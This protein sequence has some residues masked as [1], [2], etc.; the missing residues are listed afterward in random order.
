MEGSLSSLMLLFSAQ[1]CVF[2]VRYLL[3]VSNQYSSPFRSKYSNAQQLRTKYNKQY[4][5]SSVVE[6]TAA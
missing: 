2:A 1:L 3:Q 5:N 4:N 6:S